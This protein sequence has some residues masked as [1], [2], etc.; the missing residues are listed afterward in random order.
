MEGQP[1]EEWPP[2][3][4][5]RVGAAATE[6]PDEARPERRQRPEA[7][8]ER[9]AG[10]DSRAGAGSRPAAAVRSSAEVASALEAAGPKVDPGMEPPEDPAVLQ[11][12]PLHLPSGRL[13]RET[14][15]K[16]GNETRRDKPESQD[17]RL[18]RLNR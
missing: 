3:L 8:E 1:R 5:C 7:P 16:D 2:W 11:R 14:T 18:T 17:C 4:R 13:K 15:M 10:G 9:R 6:R 12:P